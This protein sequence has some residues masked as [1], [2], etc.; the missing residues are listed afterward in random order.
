MFSSK[1]YTVMVGS[2]SGTMEEVFAAND[3]IRKWNQQNAE[4]SGKLFLPVEWK[5][6]PEEL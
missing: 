4:Q 3:V 5:A 1:V 2:L 6:K